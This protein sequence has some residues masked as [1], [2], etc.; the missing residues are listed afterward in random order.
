[1]KVRVLEQLQRRYPQVGQ[2]LKRPPQNVDAVVA[3]TRHQTVQSG[4]FALRKVIRNAGVPEFAKR[5]FAGHANDVVDFVQLIELVFARKQW[6]ECEDLV[7]D[8]A[9][10]PDVDFRI[11]VSSGE[12]RL[13]RSIPSGRDVCR[14]RR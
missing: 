10:G 4:R 8:A 7:E 11:V 5:L 1:M 9:N 12:Q 13:W 2:I 3:Q 6:V 14:V